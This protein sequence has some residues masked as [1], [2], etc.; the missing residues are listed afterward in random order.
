[1]LLGPSGGGKTTLLRHLKRELTPVGTCS[2]RIRYRGRPLAELTPE[3]AAGEIGMVFQNPDAQIV[4]DTVWHELAF[5]LENLGYPPQVMRSRLAEIA[6]LFGLEPLLYQ[7]VHQLSGGQKQ[8]LNLASVLLLQPKVLLL[9]E[10]TSQLDPVA[11]RE[12]IQTVYRLSEEMSMTVI[13]SEHRLEEV[14][15]LA[16]RVWLLQD[17]ALSVQGTPRE[18]ARDAYAAGAVSGVRAYLPAAARLFFALSPP[19]IA[20]GHPEIPL[21]VREGKRWLLGTAG[22]DRRFGSTDEPAMHEGPVQ[23]LHGRS[24]GGQPTGGDMLLQCREVTFRYERDTPDVLRK[25]SLSLHQGE[26]LAVMGGNGAGKSTLLHILGGLE[27]PQRGKLTYAKG[28]KAGYLAQNPLLYFSHDTAAEELQHMAQVAGLGPEEAARGIAGLAEAFQLGGVLEQ[29]PLDLSGG[30]QQKLALAMVLLLRPAVL[31]LDE[32][33]KGLDP[34]AKERFAQLLQG[35]LQQGVSMITVTH[36]VE[37]A[38]RYATRC[39]LMFDGSITAEG[40]P[41]EFFGGNYFYTTAVNRMA[42]ELL[43][44]ALSLEDVIEAWPSTATRC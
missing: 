11:A 42:R 37:F 16:D 18:F 44:E 35:L 43:P 36:D 10:P 2:G 39:A 20:A 14:L 38:A 1:M 28:V 27:Q 30:Q 15:P 9:D 34:G 3:R 22:P 7:P 25:L 23:A 41:A 24:T 40:T 31:L 5:G 17:G 32:P 12:F 13:I 19:Q 6:A 21:T 4:M 33:T 29:H 8:L 26:W